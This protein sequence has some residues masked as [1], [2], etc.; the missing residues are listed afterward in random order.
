MSKLHLCVD[1]IYR[2]QRFR[3]HHRNREKAFKADKRLCAIAGRLV[4]E[5]KHNLKENHGMINC[6]SSLKSFYL[7]GGIAGKR[8]IPLMSLK[9]NVSAK[10]KNA[11]NMN[12]TTR[13]TLYV[14]YQVL[15]LEQYDGH[16]IESSLK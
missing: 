2:D 4:K 14:Q 6:S 3:N 9:C 13:Y 7:K 12:L 15:F 10:T 11:R 8:F 5:L 16:T 1:K